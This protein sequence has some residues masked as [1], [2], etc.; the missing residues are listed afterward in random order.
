MIAHCHPK[1]IAGIFRIGKCPL[2]NNSQSEHIIQQMK[3]VKTKD[4]ARWVRKFVERRGGRIPKFVR[5]CSPK[6]RTFTF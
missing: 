2:G 4:Q 1:C 6:V 3:P 5:G